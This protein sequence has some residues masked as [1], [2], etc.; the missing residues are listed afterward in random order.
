[1]DITLSNRV[2]KIKPSPT[3]AI[4]AQ[5]KALQAEGKDIIGLG[6][7]EPDFDTPEHIKE[8]AI[9]AIREGFTKYTAVDGIPS[10]KQAI[11][12]KFKR[13]NDL[14][15]T[16]EQILVSVGGKQSFYNLAQALLNP[17]DEAIIPA[18][19]WVS[20]PDIVLLA[21]AVPVIL[22]ASQTHQFKITPE[23][24]DTAITPL[25]RL[26]VLNSPSNPTGTAYSRRELTALGDV[27][28]RHPQVL[29]ATDD[30]Y[31]HIYWGEE[32]FCNIV[33]ACPDLYART[34]VLNGVSKAYSMTGWRIGYAAGPDEL[35]KA[36]KA[37]QTQRTSNPTSISKVAAQVAL[38]SEQNC[39]EIM[40]QEFRERHDFVVEQLNAMPG[41]QCLPG[42][43]TFYSFPHVQAAIDLHPSIKNDLELA[44]KMLNEAHVAVVPGTAFGAPGHL[45]LSFA[46]SRNNLERALERI[47]NFLKY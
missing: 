32:P 46:T 9:Q 27:L 5:A 20:Y 31:E 14:H 17:G 13:D 24:L 23:Q 33:N 28:R 39:V 36:M 18:P 12:T 16:A 21:G 19:Y 8:A 35:I 40:C 10:L 41:V 42:N 37:I 1:M 38:E 3:L 2:Q 44:E 25:T 7:G 15:Y 47:A 34:I 6:A 43:G 11:I 29:I 26:L 30:M 45:R 4:T 22:A